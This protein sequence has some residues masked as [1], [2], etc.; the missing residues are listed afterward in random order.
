MMSFS[1]IGAMFW[2]VVIT[3]V[4]VILLIVTISRNAKKVPDQPKDDS[5]GEWNF[6]DMCV[7]LQK[8]V[9]NGQEKIL[10]V[11]GMENAQR[12][13]NQQNQDLE[14]GFCILTE[15]ACY[16]VG[17]VYQK[18]GI[19]TFKKNIQHRIIASEFKGINVDSLTRFRRVVPGIIAFICFVYDLINP[20]KN[21]VLY[22]TEWHETYMYAFYSFDSDMV[23]VTGL[24]MLVISVLSA[25]VLLVLSIYYLV[26]A[27]L[28][29]RT[30][31]NLEFASI[32]ISFMV[33]D[34]GAQEIKQF[35]KAVSKMQELNENN[36]VQN[37]SMK[38]QAIVTTEPQ[39][40]KIA[41]LTELS[42]LFEKKMITEEEFKKLK[43]EVMDK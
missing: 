29:R 37:T 22:N 20:V 16:F 42:A 24:I 1:I 15:K 41:S 13:I 21:W 40:D 33:S 23:E 3:V 36:S 30:S 18:K 39:K 38:T 34:L 2:A 11:L 14:K 31:V 19:F 12:T 25:L 9:S 35:Y 43:Q 32:V 4:T 17:N 8:F 5:Q 28:M 7:K 26:T 6:A 27:V 10:S